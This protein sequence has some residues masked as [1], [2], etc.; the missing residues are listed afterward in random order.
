MSLQDVLKVLGS[1]VN[2]NDEILMYLNNS[3]I[4]S[5]PPGYWYYNKNNALMSVILQS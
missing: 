2:V 1:Q 4:F 3:N 5:F